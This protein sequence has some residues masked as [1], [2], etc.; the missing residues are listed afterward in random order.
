MLDELEPEPE[1][2][3][4]AGGDDDPALEDCDDEPP[5]PHPASA[6]APR[7]NPRAIQF[8]GDIELRVIELLL[9]VV[10]G[11]SRGIATRGRDARH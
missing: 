2:A 8:R 9:L 5:P 3:V 10:V 1:G 4:D 6:T 7:T 11:K